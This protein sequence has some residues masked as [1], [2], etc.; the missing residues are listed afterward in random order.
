[1]NG[2]GVFPQNKFIERNKKEYGERYSR[3]PFVS[4]EAARAADLTRQE[5]LLAIQPEAQVLCSGSKIVWGE[6]SPGCVG[7]GEGTW[8]CLF[9]HGHCNANC[10]FCPSEQ[11]GPDIAVT[12]CIPFENPEDYADYVERFGIKHVG[13]SGGEPLLS[14]S[15]AIGFVRHLRKRFGP[16][17]YIWLYT[18]GKLLSEDKLEGFQDAGLD[19]MRFNIIARDYEL[20]EIPRA[21]KYIPAVTVEI[22]AVPEDFEKMKTKLSELSDSGVKY[23]NLHQ[24]RLTPHN[25]EHFMKREYTYLH[26]QKVTVLESELTALRL[27]EYAKAKALR[28]SINYCSFVYKNRF[29]ALAA[30]RRGALSVRKAHED[31]TPYG[32]LR[33][34]FIATPP[35]GIESLTAKLCQQGVS[36]ELWQVKSGR[37]Y[38]GAALVNKIDFTSFKVAVVYHEARILPQVSYYHPFEEIRLNPEKKIVIERVRVSE[39]TELTLADRDFIRGVLAGQAPD[40]E[41]VISDARKQEILEYE[42]IPFGLQ[43][44]C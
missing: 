5:L 8:S 11:N 12:G 20:G 17:L 14:F 25:F 21:V 6:R 33:S 27:I 30:R 36:P 34:F 19:E 39:E 24:L 31:V 44:F 37:L 41:A 29:E 28:L 38:F 40:G 42:Y 32:Y 18:N 2:S 1:M 13:L 3:I 9:I 10:F 22:P 23:L 4:P 16:A 7:C 15:K 43:Q 35:G 26:G